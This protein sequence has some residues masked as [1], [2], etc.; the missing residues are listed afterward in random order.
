MMYVLYI[1]KVI[2]PKVGL[3]LDMHYQGSV[4]LSLLDKKKEWGNMSSPFLIM[5]DNDG[6]MTFGDLVGLTLPDICL[7]GEEK[8]R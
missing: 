1:C 6:Q 4:Y 3:S 7:T 2:C 8:P 5:D